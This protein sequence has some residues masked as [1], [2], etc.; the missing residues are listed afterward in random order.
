MLYFF[1]IAMIRPSSLANLIFFSNTLDRKG[2]F[3][4]PC[5]GQGE[6]SVHPR[7]QRRL[8]QWIPEES[9]AVGGHTEAGRDDREQREAVRYDAAVPADTV[10]ENQERALLHPQVGMSHET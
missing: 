7:D 6:R 9:A 4:H 2:Y 10:P 1:H 5:K 8:L 3:I